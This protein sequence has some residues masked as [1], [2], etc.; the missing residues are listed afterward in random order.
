MMTTWKDV[1]KNLQISQEEEA[2]IELEKELIR[3]LIE[4]REQQQLTQTQLA[5]K[6]DIH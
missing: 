3:T 4:V 1:R 6:W 5:E 2:I